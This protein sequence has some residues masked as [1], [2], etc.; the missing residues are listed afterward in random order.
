MTDDADNDGNASARA[1]AA[2]KSNGNADGAHNNDDDADK[3]EDDDDKEG[4]VQGRNPQHLRDTLGGAVGAGL[5]VR[6]FS[7]QMESPSGKAKPELDGG[8]SGDENDAGECRDGRDGRPMKTET[9]AI[10]IMRGAQIQL[11]S[12][13]MLTRCFPKQQDRRRRRSRN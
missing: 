13:L 9:G 10:V 8:C 2:A 5:N 12:G 7:N 6:S 3:G 4:Q 1:A 11:P